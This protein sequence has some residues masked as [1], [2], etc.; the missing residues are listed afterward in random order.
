MFLAVA[1]VGATGGVN[2]QDYTLLESQD[3]EDVSTY[4]KGWSTFGNVTISQTD[5]NN[6]KAFLV[7]TNDKTRDT[8]Y[9]FANSNF[10]T[11]DQWKIEF[12]FAMSAPNKDASNLSVYSEASGS[13]YG[14]FT[15]IQDCLI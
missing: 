10:I 1:L 4:S 15:S 11:S 12:D 8:Y 5:Y 6:G 3:F 7:S 14:Q 2:A 9:N 13:K